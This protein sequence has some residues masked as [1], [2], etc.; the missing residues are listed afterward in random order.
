MTKYNLQAVLIVFATV[1]GLGIF[2]LPYVFYNQNILTP[3]LIFLLVL[4]L[5]LISTIIY[6]EI[7]GRVDG[8]HN[9][10]SYFSLFF[11][12]KSKPIVFLIEFL[13]LESVLLVYSYYLKDVYGFFAGLLF[14]ILGH[15]VNFLGI[16]F[17]KKIE[18]ILAAVLFLFI[19]LI[20]FYG[21]LN[22][23]KENFVFKFENN[24]SSYG[25]ALFS[26]TGFS[27]F[28]ILKS[29][30]KDEWKNNYLKTVLIAYIIVS[31]FYLAFTFSM[32]G[33]FGKDILPDFIS[34]AKIFPK[35]I[36]Y[37]V[38][39]L[40]IL[41]IFTTFITIAIYLKEG[42]IFDWFLKPTLS[43]FFVFVPNLI[44]YF[45]NLGSFLKVLEI[46]SSIFLGIMGILI[47]FI[48]LKIKEKIFYK[49]PKFFIF[50]TILGYI[51]GI[52]SVFL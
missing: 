21:F 34:S 15:L 4:F 20:T 12:K 36:F 22:L 11:R 23:N 17:F 26:L 46:S 2:P 45:L 27:V 33:F 25:L 42:L 31:V 5:I 37:T 40:V 1:I 44:F 10:Y 29:I 18:Q 39:L 38:N 50:L 13:S 32:I 6:G 28:P 35:F 24:F 41:N 49:I 16:K 14:L 47:C 3:L 8:I 19:F 52:L 9:F 51:L 48:Y 7:I 43:S 30:F